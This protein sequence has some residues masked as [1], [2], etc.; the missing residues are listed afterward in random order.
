[1]SVVAKKRNGHRKHRPDAA[2]RAKE[3]MAAGWSRRDAEH[4]LVVEFA[5][6]VVDQL[7]ADIAP[8]LESLAGNVAIALRW[9]PVLCGAYALYTETEHAASWRALAG[10]AEEPMRDVMLRLAAYADDMDI[11]S[12]KPADLITADDL[13]IIE[14]A[15]QAES[16]GELE[17]AVRLLRTCRRPLDDAWR[18]D[19][20]HL[21]RAGDELSPAVWGRWI[22]SAAL[23]WCQT[24]TRG[25]ELG[26]HY[27]AAALR[28]LDASEE[29]VREQAYRRALYD[30]VVHDALLWDEGGLATYIERELA[31]ALAARVPGLAT[32]PAATLR[33]LRLVG[34]RAGDALC[35][36]VHTGE[37]IVVGDDRLGLQHRPGRLFFGR[38]VHVEGDARVYFAMKP[39]MCEDLGT[40]MAVA[41]AVADGCEPERRIELL[42]RSLAADAA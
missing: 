24:S 14:E 26:E 22:C 15:R 35:E 17:E 4:L 12:G 5:L 32:W 23:R 31:P 27:A 16:R 20:E 10:A 8:A 9:E 6:G 41:A 25:V 21:L 11:E 36:D 13:R 1:M 40:A 42:H 3:L 30:Q 37:P 34:E 28:A 19:L 38:L 2:P 29:I 18:R 7:G 39:T 33:V